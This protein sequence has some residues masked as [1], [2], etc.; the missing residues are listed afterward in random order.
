MLTVK[1][2]SYQHCIHCD[3]DDIEKE[4][5]IGHEWR[6]SV[7]QSKNV[8]IFFSTTDVFLFKRLPDKGSQI[9]NEDILKETRLNFCI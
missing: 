4:M 8:F 3:V 2:I 7:K 6:K 5:C 9:Q 1:S